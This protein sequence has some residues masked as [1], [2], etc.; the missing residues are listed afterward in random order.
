MFVCTCCTCHCTCIMWN[1][2]CAFNSPSMH[3]HSRRH[4]SSVQPKNMSTF[5]G[6][7]RSFYSMMHMY[8]VEHRLRLVVDVRRRSNRRICR[9][10]SAFPARCT[11]CHFHRCFRIFYRCPGF[12]GGTRPNRSSKTHRSWARR[13]ASVVASFVSSRHA[14]STVFR[15]I[16]CEQTPCRKYWGRTH[17]LSP[18]VATCCW[19]L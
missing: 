15:P 12:V 19:M 8:Y 1:F 2:D 16:P 10:S 9:R 4:S 7:P 13:P 3:I 18:Y 11:R 17:P 6:L 14:N 5:V